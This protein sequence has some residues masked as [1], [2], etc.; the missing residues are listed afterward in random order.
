MASGDGHI[1]GSPKSPSYKY[2]P[3]LAS[4][5]AVVVAYTFFAISA[6]C[7]ST[8]ERSSMHP[9]QGQGFP[10]GLYIC[11]HAKTQPT[12]LPLFWQLTAQAQLVSPICKLPKPQLTWPENICH[13]HNKVS[14][15][16]THQACCTCNIM[17]CMQQSIHIYALTGTLDA[18]KVANLSS[19]SQ[20]FPENAF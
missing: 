8:L 3:S 11:W 1:T 13:N 15:P 4:S 12:C 17:M 19:L 7:A 9:S 18:D 2:L 10:L 6:E 16:Q 5:A 20:V 14:K